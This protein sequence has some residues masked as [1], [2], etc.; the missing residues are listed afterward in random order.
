MH[1]ALHSTFIVILAVDIA[2]MG[3]VYRSYF[4]RNI[5]REL[6]PDTEKKKLVL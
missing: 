4:G 6:S 1:D 5:L 3:Y 2:V